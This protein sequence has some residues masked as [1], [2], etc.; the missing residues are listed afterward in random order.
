MSIAQFC[1]EMSCQFHLEVA[2]WMSGFPEGHPNRRLHG[3]SYL[4]RV[5]L[6]G[7]VNAGSGVLMEY[8]QLKSVIDKLV[9]ELDHRLLNEISGLEISSSENL[10]R[11]IWKAL[12]PDLP[13]LFEVQLERPSIGMSVSY[14]GEELR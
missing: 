9:S 14:F 10:A 6:R 3:H 12:R 5:K 4:G 7:P 1:A 11:W 13:E 8:S 2:H